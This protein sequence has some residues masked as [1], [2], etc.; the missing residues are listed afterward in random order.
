ML[1]NPFAFGHNLE[2]VSLQ[3]PRLPPERN[4]RTCDPRAHG[5][6]PGRL[7][8]V[9]AQKLTPDKWK[10][11]LPEWIRRK[12]CTHK[13][14]RFLVSLRTGWFK[15]GKQPGIHFIAPPPVYP[16]Y[17]MTAP[18]TQEH[19]VLNQARGRNE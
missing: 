6:Q 10:E 18:V 1:Q 15:E 3:T 16:L 17:E 19:S 12:P 2:F 9:P 13:A 14:L 5:F 7:S 11:S 4:D 8:R